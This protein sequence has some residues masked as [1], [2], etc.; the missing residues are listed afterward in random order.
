[1]KTLDS[2]VESL[3]PAFESSNTDISVGDGK[4]NFL[5]RSIVP[6]EIFVLSGSGATLET[7]AGRMIDMASMTVNTVLGQNDPWV[8]AN[9]IAYMKS[10]RPSF[11]STRFGS[12]FYYRV[13][14]RLSTIGNIKE[15]VVNHRQC[16]GSDVTELAI[17]A[18]SN[19]KGGRDTVVSFEGSY[20][21]QNMTSYFISALQERHKF[22]TSLQDR[23][24]FLPSPNNYTLGDESES[25]SEEERLIIEQIKG[26]R[27]R[28][29]AIVLEP[30]QVNNEVRVFRRSFLQ[31]IREI[32]SEDD[33]ALVY[34]EVQTAFGW[35]GEMSAAEKYA[36]PPD[37]IALS[38]GIT[39]GF[40]PL[41]A[42]VTNKKFGDFGYGTSEKTNGADVRSLV[43]ANAVMDRLLGVPEEQIPD[44]ISET[45]RDQLLRGLL[46][47]VPELTNLFEKF[48]ID[49]QEVVPDWLK[50][51]ISGDA[52][53]KGISFFGAKT[54][55]PKPE[56]AASIY[57]KLL[58]QGIYIRKS[59]H[60][61]II[62]PPLV[63]THKELDE[64][65]SKIIDVFRSIDIKDIV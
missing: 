51:R 28:I 31:E 8:K 7:N 60:T 35:L 50:I 4:E 36:I 16:N 54:M 13:A 3:A 19:H 49:L 1:M 52:L 47:D 48:F 22:L 18:A 33:I 15:P 25:C 43:A 34:D 24:W 40:G 58:E 26:E 37:M 56:L 44:A 32:C 45:L 55:S 21:G 41:S 46:A 20:H 64:A 61:L 42:L 11:L 17:L 30:I 2:L 38:K 6:G 57:K 39:A 10:D 63:I 53:I 59:N 5:A 12:E 65:F 62:K 14:N 27:D 23:V 29:Y 9:M